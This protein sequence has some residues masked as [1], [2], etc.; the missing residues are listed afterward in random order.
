MNV[1]TSKQIDSDKILIKDI[2]GDE[3]WYRIP[4]YQRPYVWGDDQIHALLE[5]V[6][7]AAINTPDSQ[8]F[9]GSI[10]L[11]TKS[12]NK[13]GIAY[14]ENDLLDGQ[15]RLTTLY[16]LMAVVRDI[17]EDEDLIRTCSEYIFQKANKFTNVPER[18]RIIFDIRDEVQDFTNDYIK[19]K[20]ATGNVESLREL[21]KKSDDVSI[22]NMANAIL[23]MRAW[24]HDENNINVDYFMPYLLNYVLMVYVASRELEDAFRLFTVLNDRGIKLR[25]SDILKAQNLKEVK[26]EAQRVKYAKLWEELE[27]ELNEDFDLFLSYIRTILVKEKARLSLLKEFEQNIYS[28]RSKNSAPLLKMGKDTFDLIKKYREHYN[29]IFSGNNYHI[30]KNYAFDNLITIL[31]D[32][33]FSDIWIPPLLAYREAFGEYRIYDFLVKLDNKFSGD[34]ISRETPTIRIENMNGILK[35]M[36]TC[37]ANHADRKKAADTLLSSHKFEFDRATFFDELYNNTVYGRRYAKYILYKLEMIYGSV[38]E[39]KPS[40][41]QISVEHILPQNPHEDSQWKKDFNAQQRDE[42]THYLGNLVLISRRK[43][44]SQGRL[45]YTDKKEKYFKT[46]IETFA[47]SLRVLNNFKTWTV[48]DVESNHTKVIDDLKVYYSK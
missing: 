43:N 19:V 7:Y 22:R 1:T 28:V 17:T 3:K 10:V 2:F 47:N 4:E 45:D 24:F 12:E 36:D 26:D 18:M 33:A 8:Y 20:G 15:Q 5:D 13:N 32:T 46:N 9:L 6:A 31:E 25:N 11:H 23:K 41:V 37:I 39:R 38:D 30:N 42:W 35:E 48:A 21:S 40:I 29:Q 16:L 44:T 27:G 34:W 14:T